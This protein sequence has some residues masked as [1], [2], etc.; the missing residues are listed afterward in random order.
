MFASADYRAK[1]AQEGH[2]ELDD[3][4][5]VPRIIILFLAEGDTSLLT[6]DA[7]PER[8][9]TLD[10]LKKFGLRYLSPQMVLDREKMER[11]L[12]ARVGESC[13][14]AKGSVRDE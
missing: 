10:L 9:I 3:L 5:L 6:E 12:R 1:R 8:D 4:P 13:V 7:V 14:R 2:R 11:D